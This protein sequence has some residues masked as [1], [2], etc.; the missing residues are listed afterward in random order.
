M[1]SIL[2]PLKPFKFLK[3]T[4]GAWANFFVL[5]FSFKL[6]I[7]LLRS[8]AV[9]DNGAGIGDARNLEILNYKQAVKRVLPIPC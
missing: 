9:A 4:M 3:K 8:K 7:H 1:W 6:P 2:Q 5:F